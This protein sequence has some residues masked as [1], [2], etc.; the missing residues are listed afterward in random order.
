[1]TDQFP[2][3]SEEP[4]GSED[5]IARLL[6]EIPLLYKAR[7][8]AES[9]KDPAFFARLGE[10]LDTRERGPAPDIETITARLGEVSAGARAQ[11]GGDL[12]PEAGASGH[13]AS[14]GRGKRRR[15]GRA[16]S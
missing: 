16:E 5:V 15:R 12:D 10:A 7:A 8:F 9:V 4:G 2:D 11:Y 3:D 13:G 14:G 1:M 6:D